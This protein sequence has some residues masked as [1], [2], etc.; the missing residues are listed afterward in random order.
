MLLKTFSVNRFVIESSISSGFIS[1][2]S[3]QLQSNDV[4]I[5]W[6]NHDKTIL[7]RA[8]GQKA[9]QKEPRAQSLACQT[10]RITPGRASASSISRQALILRRRQT[11]QSGSPEALAVSPPHTEHF[12][13]FFNRTGEMERFACSRI[14]G[15]TTGSAFGCNFRLMTFSV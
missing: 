7:F 6:K 12:A 3:N 9:G 1:L 4:Q 2:V 15:G 8:D 11:Q 13:G 14:S 5:R 10:G